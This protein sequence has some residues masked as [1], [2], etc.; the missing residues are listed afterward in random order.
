[1]VVVVA[2]VVLVSVL[3]LVDVGV[4]VGVVHLGTSPCSYTSKPVSASMYVL[5]HAS[6]ASSLIHH[7]ALI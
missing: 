2:V 7:L 5:L 1:M 3:V 4:G 6:K